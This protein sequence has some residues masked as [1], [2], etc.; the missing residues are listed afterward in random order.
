[1]AV[2]KLLIRRDGVV[3]CSICGKPM[4]AGALDLAHYKGP[5]MSKH[6]VVSRD[7][8]DSVIAV[9]SECIELAKNPNTAESLKILRTALEN[10]EGGG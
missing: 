3:D 2:G 5:S 9:C 4:S 6:H 7:V 10:Q 8:E 1:M